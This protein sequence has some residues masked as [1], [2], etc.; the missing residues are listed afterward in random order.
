LRFIS[1]EQVLK[2]RSFFSRLSECSIKVTKRAFSGPGKCKKI[3]WLEKRSKSSQ[4][5]IDSFLGVDKN[6]IPAL[7]GG[8]H[9]T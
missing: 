2:Q 6:R 8:S 5:V 4:I 1:I 9:P 7:C 3:Y